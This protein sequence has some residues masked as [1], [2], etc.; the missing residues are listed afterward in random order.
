MVWCYVTTTTGWPILNA[1]FN[2]AYANYYYYYG[3]G[4]SGWYWV[5]VGD[6][7]DLTCSASGYYSVTINVGNAPSTGQYLRFWLKPIPHSDHG[8]GW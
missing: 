4:W 6:Y 1:Y 2:Y 3:S 7:K 8:D 5:A